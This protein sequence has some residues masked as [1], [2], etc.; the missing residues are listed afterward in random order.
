MRATLQGLAPATPH[1]KWG[2]LRGPPPVLLAAKN[3][4]RQHVGPPASHK[5]LFERV[6][7]VNRLD[8]L[9]E[10]DRSHRI[11][12]QIAIKEKIK[13]TRVGL[14]DVSET[15]RQLPARLLDGGPLYRN[16]I[17][18]THEPHA[19]GTGFTVKQYRTVQV[20]EQV[21]RIENILAPGGCARAQFVI[22]QSNAVPLAGL[23]LKPIAPT[24]AWSPQVD[25]VANP[26]TR[27]GTDLMRRRLRRSP[28]CRAK[29][30]QIEISQPNGTMIGEQHARPIR[31]CILR[32]RAGT[33]KI[34]CTGLR[35]TMIKRTD[36]ILMRV[37]ERFHHRNATPH[38][39]GD[40][41]SPP[42][43]QT[44]W[45]RIFAKCTKWP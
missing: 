11:R 1:R 41:R 8:P 19:I 13:N 17:Q 23:L 15:K 3:T 4:V 18:G 9:E 28:R 39:R 16:Q 42:H 2:L 21:T 31:N 12:R 26:S 29:P 14:P 40:Q 24:T 32:P 35:R 6:G 30:V 20:P 43:T 44:R 34:R 10:V 25:N 7:I 22:D 38:L 37:D 45:G 36:C 33:D 27:N 5:R